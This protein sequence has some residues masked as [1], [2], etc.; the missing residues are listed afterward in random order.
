MDGNDNDDIM[1]QIVMIVAETVTS[2][3]SKNFQSKKIDF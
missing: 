1:E 2:A 3:I